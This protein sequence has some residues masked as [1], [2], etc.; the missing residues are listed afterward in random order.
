MKNIVACI[1]GSKLTLA[2]CEASAWGAQKLNSPLT[3]LHVL[4]KAVQPVASE[5]SGQIGLGTQEELLNELIELDELRSKIAFKHS[6]QLLDNAKE[7]AITR[8]IDDVTLLQRHGN[9][10]DTLVDTES[11][12]SLL[13]M[14]KSGEGH[15][16]D[17][18]ASKH[19]AKVGMGQII[20]SQ[21]ENI[22]RSIK[23]EILVV[24][25]HFSVPRAFMIAFDAS[26]ASCNSIEKVINS[27]LLKDLECHLVTVNSNGVANQ[28]FE[29]AAARLMQAGLSVTQRV[30]T[31][32]V[33]E[34]L[35]N[36]QQQQQLDLIVMG[37][38]SHNRLRQYFVGSNT[39][40]VLAKCSVPVLLIR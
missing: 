24:S 40:Q 13:V 19:D 32:S 36:Y 34:A 7:L 16:N 4:D 10:L 12:L 14:G 25:E 33:D 27:Q 15:C 18:Y 1:D 26:E 39:T 38:Y 3:L 21:L 5:L 17:R 9:L 37:A 31:G 8:G 30:L 2:T 6:K 11:E 23:S 20:G 22:I 29:N 28:K 35:L